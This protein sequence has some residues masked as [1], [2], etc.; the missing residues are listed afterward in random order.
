MPIDLEILMKAYANGYFPMADS[1]DDPEVMWVEPKMRA[2]LPLEG[3]KISHS[4]AKTIRQDKFHVTSNTAF[5]RVIQ[6]CAEAAMGREETW[7]NQDIQEAFLKLHELGHAHSVECWLDGAGGPQL[8]GGLY[9]VAVSRVF[10]GESMFSRANDA[11]KV[12]LAWLV[13]RLRLG[14]YEL[15]DCQFMTDHLASLGAT[16]I[17]QRQYVALLQAAV[18]GGI[19]PDQLVSTVGS[20]VAASA[21]V[22]GAS[23]AAFAPAVSG[24]DWGVLDGFLTAA[25]AGESPSLAGAAASSSSP[26][27]LILHSLTQIS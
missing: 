9:G 8:V 26:G 22:S 4:L 23:P 16:E 14:G 25:L 18:R 20:S 27:K 1:R 24:A 12:A 6:Y 3:F 7:I 10:C 13:A 21:A 11:S 17:S 19:S 2:I 15:L 5:G